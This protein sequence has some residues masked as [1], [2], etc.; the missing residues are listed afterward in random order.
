MIMIYRTLC[1]VGFI[2]VTTSCGTIINSTTQ[3]VS[4]NSNPSGAT[5]SINGQNRGTTPAVIELKRK[6]A[7]VVRI[8]LQGYNPYELALTRS[9]SG[10]VWGNIV[11]GGLIGLVIDAST[12]GMYMLKPE[13]ITADMKTMAS[14]T[15]DSS[16][17]MITVV[18]DADPSWEKVGQLTAS[19]K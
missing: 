3:S 8:E 6:D 11:F 18:L 12:G 7:H 19:V 1:L 4:I 17:L 13:Q 2:T 16:Q 15:N 10:W 5:I 9:V 14:A